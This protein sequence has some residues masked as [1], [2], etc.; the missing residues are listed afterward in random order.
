MKRFEFSPQS[1]HC[2]TPLAFSAA[3]ARRATFS[4]SPPTMKSRAFH[5]RGAAA[6][7]SLATHHSSLALTASAAPIAQIL[8][9]CAPIKNRRIPLKQHAMFF[10]NGPRIA[11]L[12]AHFARHGSPF[13]T[14][15]SRI[16]NRYSIIRS[17]P[18]L[19]ATN[20][21]TFSNRYYV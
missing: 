9:G 16:S 4:E 8:I 15:H 14:L 1:R 18:N 13:R 7:S 12:R 3:C 19:L 20:Q 21:K 17:P 5:L 6:C 10:S 11:C 2:N